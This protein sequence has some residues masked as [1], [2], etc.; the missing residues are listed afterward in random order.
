[1]VIIDI[2]NF[3]LIFWVLIMYKKMIL[4]FMMFFVSV[5]Y[6]DQIVSE[7]TLTN[8]ALYQFV[9]KWIENDSDKL[10]MGVLSTVSNNHPFTRVIGIKKIDADGIYFTSDIN[11]KKIQHIKK[12]QATSLTMVIYHSKRQITFRGDAEIVEGPKIKTFKKEQAYWKNLSQ[13][14]QLQ[15][16]DAESLALNVAKKSK[17][18]SDNNDYQ[19]VMVRIV[20][21]TIE[22]FQYNFDKGVDAF[23]TMRQDNGLWQMS[24]NE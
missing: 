3:W 18:A 23:T 9:E 4:F 2:V 11:S 15:T 5:S 17:S 13:N 24:L 12:N 10:K 14:S 1:M 19:Q 20:P 22:F 8:Q 7:Q 21:E 6:A 16:K